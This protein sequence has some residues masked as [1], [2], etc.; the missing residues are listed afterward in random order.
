MNT[1]KCLFDQA[2]RRRHHAGPAIGLEIFSFCAL[3]AA[4]ILLVPAAARANLLVGNLPAGG[5]GYAISTA[6]GN[7]FG[8]AVEF[9]PLQDGCFSSVTLWISGYN[10]LGGSTLSL[11]LMDTS[12]DGFPVSGPG[13]TIADASAAPNDG[14]DAAFTFNM[15]GQLNANTPYW[16]FLYL[17]V[18]GGGIGP[19]YG[20]FNCYWDSG[21]TPTGDGVVNGSEAFVNGFYP[22]SFQSG[23][24]AFSINSVPELPPTAALLAMAAG[25]CL[26]ARHYWRRN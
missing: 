19:N 20:N 18:P 13:Q 15:A 7:T 1:Y 24:P 10:G 6:A 25:C 3:L 14:T 8:R 22:P 16:L 5:A 2:V 26:I 12:A 23:A 21:G 17:Q 11:A 9:T 4:S